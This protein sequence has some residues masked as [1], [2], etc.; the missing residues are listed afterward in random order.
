MRYLNLFEKVTKIR[1]RFCFMYNDTLMFVVPKTFLVRAIGENSKNLKKINEIIGKK[2]R[3]VPMPNGID[4]VK[5]FISKIISPVE[6]KDVEVKENEVVINAGSN[7]K[8]AL[9]GRNK[10]RLLEMQRIIK[11]YFEKEMRIV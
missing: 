3:V 5:M 6:F 8:A 11:D 1:T 10:R 7:N 4:D 9:I 2:I